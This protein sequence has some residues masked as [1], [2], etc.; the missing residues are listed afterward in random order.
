MR[1]ITGAP[2]PPKPEHAWP[3]P[4]TSRCSTTE[5]GCTP[6]SAT[7]P[8]SKPSPTTPPEWQP[9]HDQ[10]PEDLSKILDTAQ[11]PSRPSPAGGLRPALTPA[12]ADG[13]PGPPERPGRTL[14]KTRSPNRSLYSSGGLPGG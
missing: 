5:S 8:R 9:L 6:P 10:S 12:P 2:G 14:T 3:S 13:Q 11:P 7:A 4:S 1:C